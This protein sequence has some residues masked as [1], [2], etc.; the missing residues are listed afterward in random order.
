MIPQDRTLFDGIY[1]VPP[2]HFLLATGGQVRLIR[3]W[4]FDYP[5]ADE[6]PD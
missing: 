6:G 4:D 1:Q 2:G 5:L 3:Y